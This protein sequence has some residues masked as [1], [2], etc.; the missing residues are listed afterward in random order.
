MLDRS[1]IQESCKTKVYNFLLKP[2]PSPQLNDA[3]YV[4]YRQNTTT[5]ILQ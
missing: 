3:N 4:K 1:N 2:V 5:L